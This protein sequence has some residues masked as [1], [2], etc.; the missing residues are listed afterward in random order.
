MASVLC[1]G[2][3]QGLLNTRKLILERAGH[4]VIPALGEKELVS[5]CT[6]YAFDVAVIGQTVSELEKR[7][8]LRLIREHCPRATVLELFS[9]ATGKMLPD[10]DDWLEVPAKIPFDLA[11]RVS[12]LVSRRSGASSS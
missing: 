9:P 10:A 7:R 6:T 8:I 12:M 4:K 11:Q 2:V 5:A 1:T 3:D